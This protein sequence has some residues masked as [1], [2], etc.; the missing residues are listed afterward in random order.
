[1]ELNNIIKILG[2]KDKG[3]RKGRGMASGKGGHTTGAGNKGQKAR[4]GNKHLQG[5]EGGQVP[6]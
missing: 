3:K 2:N 4:A 1:M 5:F 6:L